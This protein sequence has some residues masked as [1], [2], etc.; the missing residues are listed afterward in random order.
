MVTFIVGPDKQSFV[1]HKHLASAHSPFIRAAFESK[2]LEGITQTMHLEDINCSTF[3]M[4]VHFLYTAQLD[5]SSY[6]IPGYD[7]IDDPTGPPCRSDDYN[8]VQLAKL[9]ELAERL[10]MPTLQ[11]Y[12]VSEIWRAADEGWVSE[13]RLRAFVAYVCETD[14][15]GGDANRGYLLREVVVNIAA[16]SQYKCIM[17]WIPDS[18]CREVAD[19]LKRQYHKK[20]GTKV[21]R[22]EHFFV[23]VEPGEEVS[24]ID[25]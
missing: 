9:W 14:E 4:L 3:G 24:R 6:F 16:W 12:A 8:L 21:A 10:L 1:V 20:D 15:G 18:I 5:E 23:V 25:G 17:N 22:E 19:L 11:N 2:M 7:P 13:E